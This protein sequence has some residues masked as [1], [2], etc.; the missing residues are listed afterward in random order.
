MELIKEAKETGINLETKLWRSLHCKD[1]KEV[2]SEKNQNSDNKNDQSL[3]PKQY[4]FNNV[5][6]FTGDNGSLYA[7]EDDMSSIGGG[8]S[9]S[10]SVNQ[11]IPS[12]V[13]NNNNQGSNHHSAVQQAVGII[14]LRTSTNHLVVKL[15]DRVSQQMFVMDFR[16]QETSNE[17]LYME[18]GTNINVMRKVFKV[19]AHSGRMVDMEVFSNDFTKQNIEICNGLACVTDEFGH[20]LLIGVKEAPYIPDNTHS[21]LST[22]QA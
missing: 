14:G 13:D 12:T 9:T 8:P 20:K 2:I 18:S 22:N 15:S 3:L 7:T 1:R 4:G 16:T 19:I 10:P 17:Q 11:L 5:Q 21:R 6:I